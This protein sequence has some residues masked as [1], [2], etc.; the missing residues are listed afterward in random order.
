MGKR[1]CFRRFIASTMAV[2]MMAALCLVAV[3]TKAVAAGKI[4]VAITKSSAE[5]DLTV[6]VG[7]KLQLKVTKNGKTLGKTA[8]TY[9]VKGKAISVTNTGVIIGKKKGDAQI[10]VKEKKGNYKTTIHVAVTGASGTSKKYKIDKIWLDRAS[11]TLDLDQGYQAWVFCSGEDKDRG[12]VI[13]GTDNDGIASVTGNGFI[14]ATGHGSTRIYA[15]K[16]GRTAAMMV[17]VN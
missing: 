11:L 8:V 1:D 13:W 10:Q 7:K 6:K 2:V 16:G 14:R 3:P 4:S 17:H 5:Q 15:T 12:S 9:K